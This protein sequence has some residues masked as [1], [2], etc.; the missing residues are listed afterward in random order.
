MAKEVPEDTMATEVQDDARVLDS[1][2]R[3]RPRF[4]LD[5]PSDPD[6][7]ALVAAFE[8]G[9]F[10]AVNAGAASLREK[11]DDATI[12]AA[13]DELLLRIRPDPLVKA[14]LGISV[15]LFA[16]LVAWSYFRDS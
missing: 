11:T 12:R 9:N 3:Y 4:V 14:L 15:F 8:R 13:C 2:G 1:E 7:D 10:R 6:L 5:F 16:A